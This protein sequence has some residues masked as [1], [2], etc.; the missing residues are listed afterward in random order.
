[1]K[2]L[3]NKGFSLVELIIVIAIMVILVAVLAPQ[4]T[5]WV[6]NS[7]KSTDVQSVAEIVSTLQVYHVDP[8][9]ASDKKLANG[10]ITLTTTNTAVA[11]TNATGNGDKALKEY[12][13]EYIGLKS[14][15]WFA[16]G[17]NTI[18]ITY[19]ITDGKITFDETN[20]KSEKS[21]LNGKY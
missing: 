20:L 5:K 10:K 11:E 6:E 8:T 14:S 3:N 15:E 12:G 18:E 17:Q 4:F 2:K 19:T 7:R 13:I 1:M 16:D 21:I 9:V